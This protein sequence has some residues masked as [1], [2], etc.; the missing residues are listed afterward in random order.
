MCVKAHLSEWAGVRGSYHACLSV[1]RYYPAV[2]VRP[3]L[4][5]RSLHVTGYWLRTRTH[6]RP[7]EA[8]GTRGGR[9]TRVTQRHV[10]PSGVGLDTHGARPYPVTSNQ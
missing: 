10:T 6:H 3:G 1:P 7:V 2:L 8:T 5:C 4:L 9:D